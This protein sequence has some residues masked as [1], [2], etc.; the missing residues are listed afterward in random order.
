MGACLLFFLNSLTVVTDIRLSHPWLL[1][2]L[3]VSGA[4]LLISMRDQWRPSSRGVQLT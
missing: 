4:L 1:C 2:L 3:P